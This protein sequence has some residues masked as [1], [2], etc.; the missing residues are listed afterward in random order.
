MRLN[1]RMQ[2]L[3]SLLMGRTI[4]Q[5]A[6]IAGIGTR[7]LYRWLQEDESFRASLRSAEKQALDA[8]G[9][10]LVG[11]ADTA[12]TALGNV[13]MKPAER[14]QNVRRLAARDIL[15]LVVKWRELTSFEERLTALE[16]R[17]NE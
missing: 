4:D 2:A 3:E 12:L 1:K 16:Q 7:T 11:M 17:Q 14:G 15:D 5:A 10:R 13:L 6:E 8:V 9:I